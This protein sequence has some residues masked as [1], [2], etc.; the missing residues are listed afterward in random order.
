MTVRIKKYDCF[1]ENVTFVGMAQQGKS[2]LAEKLILQELGSYSDASGNHPINWWLFD[3]KHQ[4]GWW[5]PE[6]HPPGWDT[7][8]TGAK[9]IH[10]LADLTEGKFIIQPPKDADSD[11]MFNDLCKIVRGVLN[12]IIIVEETQEFVGKNWMP[13]DF[14][15][16][17]RTGC[18]TGNTYIVLTQR[19]AEIHNAILSNAHH[20]F[21]FRLQ[22][23]PDQKVVGDWIGDQESVEW[24][25]HAPPYHYL[26][27]HYLDTK[28][29]RCDPA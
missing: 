1:G 4:H 10:T 20:R 25:S 29:E 17:V 9:V 21:I 12:Q 8:T 7:Y 5:P 13:R 14:K 28:P 6:R 26:Y 19:P 22:W 2:F 16:I 23:K 11:E 18:N 27:H 24:L 15:E 3:L